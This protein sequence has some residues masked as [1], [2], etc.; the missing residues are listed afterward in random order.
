VLL[1]PGERV[2]LLLRFAEHTGTYMIH[3]HILEHE[4]MGLMRDIA[5]VA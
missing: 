4:D 3:C 1:M 5:V 2:R